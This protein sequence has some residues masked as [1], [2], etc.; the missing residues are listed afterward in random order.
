MAP[1]GPSTCTTTWTTSTLVPLVVVPQQPAT[2][3]ISLEFEFDTMNDGTNHAIITTS[4]TTPRSSPRSCPSSRSARTRRSRARTGPQ[5][6]VLDHL[7]V[8]EIIIKNAD[9]GKHP[10]CVCLCVCAACGASPL[11]AADASFFLCHLHGHKVQIVGRSTDYTSDDPMLN[12][13]HRRRPGGT[14]CGATPS[15]SPQASP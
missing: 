11:F 15:K 7:D 13:T 10:L 14:P 8:V 6:F 12:P 3:T 5:S 1:G 4:R 9:S 2:R